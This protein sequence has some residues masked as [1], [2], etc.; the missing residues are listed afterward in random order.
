VLSISNRGTEDDALVDVS[1]DAFGDVEIDSGGTA[2]GDEI[3]IPAGGLVHVDG[4][5][6][7]ITLTE[8]AESLTAGQMIEVTFTFETAGE[9]TVP[10]TPSTPDR[11]LPRGDSFDF[12]HEEGEEAAEGAE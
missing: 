6:I 5:E 4:D 12:H 9:V 7:S 3:E 11:D 1:G 8:L 10:V 2:G